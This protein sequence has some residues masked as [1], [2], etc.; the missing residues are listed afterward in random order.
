VGESPAYHLVIGIDPGQSTGLVALRDG[1]LFGVR[2]GDWR[3]VMVTLRG[4]LHAA[5]EDGVD[6]VIAIERFATTN[7]PGRRTTQPLAT[8]ICGAVDLLADV[9]GASVTRQSP[10]D[11]K[12]LTTNT[13]L[14]NMGLWVRQT[15]VD[16]PDA[17]DANDAMRHALLYLA[18]YRA[19]L[20]QK[21]RDRTDT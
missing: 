18:T 19:T 9:Y 1:Q 7:R 16:R 15:D 3:S 12:K 10:A 4:L 14:R 6:A 17:N 8:Q 20:Y 5:R 13:D 21:L 11:A 2:Q